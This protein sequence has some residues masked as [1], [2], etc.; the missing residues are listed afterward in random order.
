MKHV[1]KPRVFL[2]ALAAFCMTASLAAC[3]Q[4]TPAPAASQAAPAAAASGGYKAPF[5][6]SKPVVINIVDV[7]GNAQLS[8]GALDAFKAQH[9]EIASDIT[10]TKLTAPELA[11]K[12]KAQQDA[13]N[14]DTT[15]VLTGFDGL[16]ACIDQNLI[17]QLMPAYSA[18]FQPII[19]NYLP[20]AKGAYDIG[21]GYG[22]VT[23]FC[24]GGPM[25]TYNPDAV[26][27]PIKTPA[28]LLA[29]AKE[30]PNKFMYARPANS[31]PGRGF[32]MGLPYLLGDSD[33]K[34]PD[35]WDKTWAFL[36]E[37]D[38]Y[39]EYYPTGTAAVFKEL[40]EGTR[41]MVASH[42]GWDM[43]QRILGT[44]PANYQ[45]SFFDGQ[46][47]VNDAHFAC[48]PKGLSDDLKNA[49]LDLT[50]WL[51][52]PDMQAITYDN[53]YFYPGPAIKGIT[54]DMAPAASIEKVKA[55][56]R[57]EYD[58]AITTFPNTTQLTPA[59]M[60]KAYDLWDKLVGAKTQK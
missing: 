27:T 34:N 48:I 59:A 54:I 11:S 47:F 53:G 22:I 6:V 4:S 56:M 26:K 13:N 7:A 30:H 8:Q 39:I 35:T 5:A 21:G 25:L 19:D 57:P 20:G 40:G 58:K 1:L 28:D 38:Q 2:A 37:L 36:K 44:I 42:I 41:D 12:I 55:A 43:N 29:W 45:G 23:V 33:P 51:M 24:P 31:G 18:Q 16:S 14:M 46:T 60:V 32:L 50:V 49:A 15:M 3:G 10:V 52:Q 9:P 17:E